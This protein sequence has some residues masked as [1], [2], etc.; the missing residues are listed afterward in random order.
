MHSFV[1]FVLTVP[2]STQ[3]DLPS[4][5]LPLS[6]FHINISAVNVTAYNA[7]ITWPPL[8]D[9]QRQYISEFRLKYKSLSYDGPTWDTTINFRPEIKQYTILD[10]RPAR[11]YVVN[12]VVLVGNPRVAVTVNTNMLEIDTLW[13]PCKYSMTFV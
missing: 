13:I 11:S 5:P 3:D 1:C 10:L 9:I 6:A 7:T 12:L 2:P 4:L 8:T